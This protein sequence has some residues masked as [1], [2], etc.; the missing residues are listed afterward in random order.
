ME[1]SNVIKEIYSPSIPQEL[2]FLLAVFA[3]CRRKRNPSCYLCHL[4]I[5]ALISTIDY[6]PWNFNV[7]KIQHVQFLAKVL[8]SIPF[9]LF[10][11]LI[12]QILGDL[13]NQKHKG[14]FWS[15]SCN[16]DEE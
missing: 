10:W 15:Y 4:E 8:A 13:M 2:A 5:S 6:F 12:N 7:F 14:F 11:P 9:L 3:C 1:N 16:T